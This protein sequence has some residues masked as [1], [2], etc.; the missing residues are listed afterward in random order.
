MHA[1]GQ[2][3]AL[4]ALFAT[5]YAERRPA[6]VA[7]LG[8]ST[9]ADLQQ[10][11]DAVTHQT[12]GVDLNP[13]YLAIAAQRVGPRLT[14]VD[15]RVRLVHADVLQVELP[16]GGFDLIHA[17]LLLEYVEPS[18][19]LARISRWLAPAGTCSVVTQQPS[20]T[21]PAVSD[22]GYARLRLLGGHMVVRAAA[23]VAALAVRA[24]FRLLAQH[25]VDLPTGKTLVGSC[26]AKAH[27]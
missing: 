6:R 11:D 20:D 24:G 12:V 5:V 9:G 1:V 13:E 23:E 8:C 10:V 3:A 7:V 25:A 17:P 27:G 2:S 26:F 4:R 14:A 15:A 19:L 18:A 16:A 21:L 22:T